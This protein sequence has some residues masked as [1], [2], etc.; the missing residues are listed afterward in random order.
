MDPQHPDAKHG[1]DP[2]SSA[3]GSLKLVMEKIPNGKCSFEMKF[4]G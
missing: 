3:V 4:D 2:D 1:K